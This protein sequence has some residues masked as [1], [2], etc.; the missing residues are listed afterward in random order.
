MNEIQLG[1]TVQD[2][3]SNYVGIAVAKTEFINKCV[4]W[5]VTGKVGKDNKMSLENEVGIDAQSLKIVKRGKI[6]KEVDEDIARILKEERKKNA[7]KD[8]PVKIKSSGTGGPNTRGIKMRG[9]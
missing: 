6:G 5:S 3:Y 7:A 4:Q 2:I 9:F 1:D 8:Y